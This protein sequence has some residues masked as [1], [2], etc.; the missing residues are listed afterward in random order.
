[1]FLAS[2]LLGVPQRQ[3]SASPIKWKKLLDVLVLS[4]LITCVHHAQ[5]RGGHPGTMG[6]EMKR[7]GHNI[8]ADS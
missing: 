8:V 5:P 7:N 1:M 3:L 4:F 2:E 6:I